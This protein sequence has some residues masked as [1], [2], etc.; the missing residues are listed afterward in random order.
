MQKEKTILLKSVN[1]EKF[2]LG[3][4]IPR[5]GP[6]F[7]KVVATDV[8]VVTRS[9]PSIDTISIAPQ[10]TIIY[11]KKKPSRARTNRWKNCHCEYKYTHSAYPMSEA[12]PE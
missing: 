11:I 6:T 5:P 2:P 8:I 4:T 12:P 10:K 3:P 1:S 7:P 9:L